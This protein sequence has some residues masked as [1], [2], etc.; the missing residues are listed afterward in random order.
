[1]DFDPIDYGC[2]CSRYRESLP[3]SDDAIQ[4]HFIDLLH[5]EKLRR[6]NASIGLSVLQTSQVDLVDVPLDSIWEIKLFGV[7]PELWIAA[8]VVVSA[9]LSRVIVKS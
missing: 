5:V 7:F 8:S 1:M 4:S 2:S 9:T 6:S 3:F